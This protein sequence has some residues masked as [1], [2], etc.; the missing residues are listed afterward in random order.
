MKCTVS[1]QM[2]WVILYINTYVYV[3]FF[4]E[5]RHVVYRIIMFQISLRLF[6]CLCM[7]V[8]AHKNVI[9]K[10][11]IPPELLII[12]I[13]TYMLHSLDGLGNM[14]VHGSHS[15]S[16]CKWKQANNSPIH[17]PSHHPVFDCFQSS[18]K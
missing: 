6:M 11:I 12:P 18:N 17:R 8:H 13:A 16:T 1:A 9:E 2:H 7:H 4:M 15:K 14:H 3:C 10:K 5:K